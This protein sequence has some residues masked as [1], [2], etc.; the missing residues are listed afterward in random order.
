MESDETFAEFTLESPVFRSVQSTLSIEQQPTND[1]L[2]VGFS[3][4]GKDVFSMDLGFD[5]PNLAN[6]GISQGSLTLQDSDKIVSC[7]EVMRKSPFYDIFSSGF[8][9]SCVGSE[10]DTKKHGSMRR[11][12]SAA[13]SQR[14]LLEQ[15]TMVSGTIDRFVEIIG[16]KSITE[17]L[18][19]TKWYEMVSFDILGEMAFGESFHSIETEHLYFITLVDNLSRL[20]FAVAIS[21]VLF[22]S[23][24]LA[25]N[26]NSEFS[27]KQVEKRL[28]SRSSRK[29]FLTHLVQKVRDGEVEQEEMTAH[30]STLAI[31]GGETVSTFLAGTTFFLL[32]KPSTMKKLTTEIRDAFPTYDTINA[33]RAQQLPYLQAVIQEGLRMYPP[34]SQGFPRISPGF[35]LHGKYVPQG[36]EVYTSAWTVTHDPQYWE[37]PM[38]FA[39]ER[40]LDNDSQDIREASQPFSLGPRGCLGRNFA[41]MEMFL[42]LAKML[43]RYDLELVNKDVGW[44]DE[45][46]VY[47]MWWKPKLMIRFHPRVDV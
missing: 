29:D 4:S 46:K 22:P 15:E 5:E 41:Y 20:P 8:K 36:V 19:M 18:N 6:H 16:K 38:E 27:R 43:W 37:N 34:G 24:L 21:R 2:E 44:L 1:A 32:N 12:L 28:S 39:P 3:P 47:V 23:M 9:H 17:P 25:K 35:E 26:H 14:A 10:R 40:W 45:G 31:A 42:L 13:F 7:K 11:M 33:Q 30:V